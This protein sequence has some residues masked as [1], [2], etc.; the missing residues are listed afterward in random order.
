MIT[1][2]EI[3][4]PEASD[5]RF[6]LLG[7]RG[8]QPAEDHEGNRGW[9]EIVTKILKGKDKQSHH[10]RIAGAGNYKTIY[11]LHGSPRNWRLD[12]LKWDRTVTEIALAA[13]LEFKIA[14]KT[15]N[16]GIIALMMGTPTGVER[17]YTDEEDIKMGICGRCGKPNVGRILQKCGRCRVSFYCSTACQKAKWPQ[18]K[19]YCKVLRDE[20]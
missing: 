19:D 17:G 13:S 15:Q 2:T 7:G 20:Y 4:A 14:P 6:E 5:G 9:Q 1:V 18:H 8:A 10:N 12:P 16:P 3:R 11:R